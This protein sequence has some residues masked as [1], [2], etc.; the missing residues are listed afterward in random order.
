[1]ESR[2]ASATLVGVLAVTLGL[3]TEGRPAGAAPVSRQVGD[4]LRGLTQQLLDAIAPG[5]VATWESLAHP[6]LI[7]VDETGRVR[8]KAE[9]LKALRPLGAG[10]VGRL[11]IDTFR[12]EQ[13]GEVVVVTHEDDEMLDY[14]GQILRSR[15]RATDAWRHTKERGWQLVSSQVLALQIDPPAIT[16]TSEELCRY[17]GVYA[18]TAAISATVQ[19]VDGGL[20][21]ERT[22]R[23]AVVYRP[24]VRDVFFLP[25]EPRTRRIVQRDE[26]AQIVGFVDRREG[27]DIRWR[28]T[29]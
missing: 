5:D 21:I 14:Y 19:C 22:D 6:D 8:T 12:A 7:H 29:Q 11:A 16:L 25:G 20:R 28:K 23:P 15:F 1:M 24:E 2:R 4:E 3:G 26:N 9:F 17:N 13:H 10:L 18:L 27:R